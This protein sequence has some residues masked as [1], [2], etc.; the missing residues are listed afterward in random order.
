PVGDRLPG[1]QGVVYGAAL[2]L[3]MLFAPEG[4][5]WRLHALRPARRAVEAPRVS[6]AAPRTDTT[7]AGRTPVE[8]GAGLLE[9]RGGSRAFLGLC[10]L[11]DVSFSVSAGE[12]VGVIGPNGAGKTTLFNVLNGFL[13]PDAG[14]VRYRGTPI[15]GLR[16]SAICRRGI[17]RTFQVVRTFPQLTVLDN[18][19][20]GAFAHGTS[21]P[22]ARERALAAMAA[23]GL[24][25]A[26][27]VPGALT[28]LDL[29][30][31]ELAR[32]LA[33]AP[34]LIL[35]DEPLAG[36][37]RDGV[38]TMAAL[39]RRVRDAGVSVVIIEHTMYAVVQLVDRLVVLDH[40]HRIAEGL[41][42]DVVR[43]PAVI[44]AYL[45]QRW[46]RHVEGLRTGGPGGPDMAPQTP[47]PSGRRGEPASPLD[48]CVR[49]RD[50]ASRT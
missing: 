1:I 37:A 4:I 14:Q 13:L 45:G 39:V 16:P 30:L 40:G 6:A 10:A 27:D 44:E 35:L 23:V 17:G 33:S 21:P 42:N 36:L 5:Y 3:V 34:D 31:M 22:R 26:D 32:C 43:D 20:V 46:L 24:G 29:R 49:S 28:T 12:I 50:V 11:D 47:Q 9:G 2:V 18:V 41:P 15:H 7:V 48:P 19:M 8:R 38:E 25:R